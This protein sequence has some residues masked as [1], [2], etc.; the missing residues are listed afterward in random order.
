MFYVAT[1]SRQQ[2]TQALELPASSMTAHRVT[3]GINHEIP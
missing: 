3:P 2:D 1:V